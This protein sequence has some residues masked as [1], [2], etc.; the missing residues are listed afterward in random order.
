MGGGGSNAAGGGGGG[1][2]GGSNIRGSNGQ[3]KAPQ[4]QQTEDEQQFISVNGFN[5]AEV[6]SFLERDKAGLGSAY[7]VAETPGA[8]RGSG[9]SGSAWGVKGT[10]FFSIFGL[11]DTDLMRLDEY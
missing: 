5:G 11:C 4:Q 1:G 9:G 10:A 2:G 6:T 3:P 8:G 7:R